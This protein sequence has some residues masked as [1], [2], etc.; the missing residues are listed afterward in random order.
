MRTRIFGYGARILDHDAAKIAQIEEKKMQG[1]STR[2]KGTILTS[3]R[4]RG[5]WW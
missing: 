2:R 3:R 1:T 5:R 4:R